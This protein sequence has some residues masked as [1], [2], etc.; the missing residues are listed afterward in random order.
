[1]HDNSHAKTPYW[2]QI[3]NLNLSPLNNHLVQISEKSVKKMKVSFD[4][5]CNLDFFLKIIRIYI[6]VSTWKVI[7][8]RN[9]WQYPSSNFR[10]SSEKLSRQT[11]G[12]NFKRNCRRSF[13][14]FFI[15]EKQKFKLNLFSVFVDSWREYELDLEFWK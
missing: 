10:I 1:M 5:N 12:I 2:N 15:W 3:F 8:K 14:L 11:R 7:F 13:T 4:L 6:F 9:C